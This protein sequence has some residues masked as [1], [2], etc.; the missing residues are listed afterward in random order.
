MLVTEFHG[1]CRIDLAA[2]AHVVVDLLTDVA[3]LPEWNAHVERV[4]EAPAGPLGEGV[5]W[6][7]LMH[8][9]GRRW[10]SRS[11]VSVLDPEAMRFEHTSR[12]DDGNP[13]FTL[14]SWQVTAQRDGC[15][16]A[17]TWTGQPKTFWRRALLIRMRAP[18]LRREVQSSLGGIDTYLT[19]RAALPN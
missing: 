4:I 15:E 9:M 7:V 13:S 19:S 11:R 5:E 17:V 16:L 3:R 6:V 18:A 1:S 14:W 2:P 10:P 12:S 8:A